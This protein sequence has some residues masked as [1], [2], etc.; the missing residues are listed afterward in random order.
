MEPIDLLMFRLTVAKVISLESVLKQHHPDVFNDYIMEVAPQIAAI[1]SGLETAFE[2]NPEL[3]ASFPDDIDY[4]LKMTRK[5]YK[6]FPVSPDDPL[7]HK[8]P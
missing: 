4:L 5:Y 1:T 6:I 7:G 3:Y 2:N 8:L